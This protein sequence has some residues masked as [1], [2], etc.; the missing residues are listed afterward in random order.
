MTEDLSRSEVITR[1]FEL[2]EQ[3]S[4]IQARHKVE[5][6]PLVEGLGLCERYVADSMNKANEQSVKID[7]VGMTYFTTKSKCQVRDWD[8][9]LA[10]RQRLWRFGLGVAE[11][12]DTAQRG[13]GLDWPTSLELIRRG[14]ATRAA[15]GGDSASWQARPARHPGRSGRGVPS[16]RCRE[17]RS[18]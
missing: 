3:I 12:M 2:D 6:A 14:L 17:S 1:R 8:A 10:V 15:A 16:G 18:T 11:A 4:L 5:L 13:M 9:T 7:G